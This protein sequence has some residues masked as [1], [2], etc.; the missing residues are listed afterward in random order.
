VN[1]RA[2]VVLGIAA[3]LAVVVGLLV[4][5]GEILAGLLARIGVVQRPAVTEVMTSGNT[6]VMRTPGGTLE[7]ARIKAYETLRRTSPGAEVFW[8]LVD[9]GDTVSEIDAAVLFRY[10]I[11]LAKEW[12]I[13]CDRAVC[14]VRAAAIQPTLPPAVYSDEVRK[15][16]ASGWAR[17]DKNENLAL[18][19]RGMTAELGKRA[20]TPR[21]LA[22]ATDAGRR[23]VRE[24]V[25]TWLLKSHL[26]PGQAAPRI[27][28]LF[29]GET[30]E[31]GPRQD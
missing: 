2:L 8:G 9:T 1:P 24:F 27:V 7:V 29:P 11:A 14:V 19:E 3:A 30:A 12:P 16:T 10:H 18:L 21:N 23:T 15:R 6:I 28:V 26:Q 25:T 13:R 17:F 5:Q 20:S 22:A 4:R 31:P